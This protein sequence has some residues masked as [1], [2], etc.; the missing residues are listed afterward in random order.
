[1]KYYTRKVTAIQVLSII[2]LLFSGFL[3]GNPEFTVEF[4]QN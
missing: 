1:M 4:T 3:A 2:Y